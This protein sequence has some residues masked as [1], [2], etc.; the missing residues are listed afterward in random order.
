MIIPQLRGNRVT[1]FSDT[2]EGFACFSL[3]FS[4]IRGMTVCR[5]YLM[6]TV[7]VV[8]RAEKTLLKRMCES[9]TE[10]HELKQQWSICIK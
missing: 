4:M 6:G 7:V 9:V 1:N 3:C 2:Q 10:N 5:T 8:P